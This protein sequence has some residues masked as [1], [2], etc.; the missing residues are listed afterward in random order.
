MRIVSNPCCK[1]AVPL[2]RI[3][4]TNGN[5]VFFY[6]YFLD[7]PFSINRE[8]LAGLGTQECIHHQAEH[9]FFCT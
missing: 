8:S 6:G 2:H 7:V 3:S 9:K 5:S 1:K 4:K